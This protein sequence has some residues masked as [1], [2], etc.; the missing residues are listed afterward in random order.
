MCIADE[1]MVLDANHQAY[2]L[3]LLHFTYLII[4]LDNK[5]GFKWEGAEEM[6]SSYVFCDKRGQLPFQM[7][8]FYLI[9]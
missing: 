2:W 1:G 9:L 4:T 8:E 6:E 7:V 5:Y 3:S